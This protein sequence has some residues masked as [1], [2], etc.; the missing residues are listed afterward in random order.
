MYPAL[1]GGETYE[2]TGDVTQAAKSA[3]IGLAYPVL[4]RAV[5]P[6]AAALINRLGAAGSPVAQKAIETTVD[7]GL[8]QAFTHVISLPEYAQM[9]PEQRDRAIAENTGN[10]LVFALPRVVGYTAGHP[11]EYEAAIRQESARLTD[12]FQQQ[13]QPEAAATEDPRYTEI[14]RSL[15]GPRRSAAEF[16]AEQGIPIEVKPAPSEA[17]PAAPA[18]EAAKVEVPSATIR[19][20]E[21]AQ[22]PLEV[23]AES[24]QEVGEGIPVQQQE[25]AG[26]RPI[27]PEVKAEAAP[28]EAGARITLRNNIGTDLSLGAEYRPRLNNNIIII[29]GASCLIPGQGFRDLYNPLVGRVDTLGAAFINATLTY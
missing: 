1:F 21:P 28:P 5:K 15:T 7:Q 20:R 27:A 12:Y 19:Q 25:P 9:T 24:R 18:T 3:T 26:T 22:I 10:I 4:G 11:G 14:L 6:L 16:A 23:P 29:G 2:R 8:M 17:A 13:R